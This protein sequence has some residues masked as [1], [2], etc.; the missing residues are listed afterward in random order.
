[1]SPCN[2]PKAM[3]DPEKVK[4]PMMA[5]AAISRRDPGFKVILRL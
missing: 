2:F 5:P 4:A 1:M 3:M